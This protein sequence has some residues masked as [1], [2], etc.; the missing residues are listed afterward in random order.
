[1]LL[2]LVQLRLQQV[3]Q[4][5]FRQLGDYVLAQL[6]GLDTGFQ[7]SGEPVADVSQRHKDLNR[8]LSTG[9]GVAGEA[10]R[11]YNDLR[12]A[13]EG[14]RLVDEGIVQLERFTKLG[15]DDKA[16]A[17]SRAMVIFNS[18]VDTG[19]LATTNL[20]GV[21]GEIR[22]TLKATGIEG[23][24]DLKTFENFIRKFKAQAIE[25]Q[26]AA[27]AAEAMR[28]TLERAAKATDFFN[29][30]VERL[31]KA[32]ETATGRIIAGMDNISSEVDQILTDRFK[33]TAVKSINPFEDVRSASPRELEAGFRTIQRFNPG[34]DLSELRELTNVQRALPAVLQSVVR[35]AEAGNIGD[36][37]SDLMPEIRKQLLAVSPNLQGEFFRELEGQIFAPGA[38]GQEQQAVIPLDQLRKAAKGSA[39]DISKFGGIASKTLARLL[40]AQQKFVDGLV[41]MGNLR[42]KVL[43]DRINREMKS[44]DRRIQLQDALN[45]ALGRTPNE[46]QNATSN[47]QERLDTLAAAGG[48]GARVN[49]VGIGQLFRNREQGLA[50][51]AMA[52]AEARRPG[53]SPDRQAFLLGRQIPRINTFLNSNTEA[54]KQLANDTTR[55]AAA[56][57]EMENSFR[58]EAEAGR[59]I[60]Q[61]GQAIVDL[62]TGKLST[63]EFRKQVATPIA[64]FEEFF[65][66]LT[67]GQQVNLSGQAGFELSQMLASGDPLL[68]AQFDELFRILAIQR[69]TDPGTERR[70]I[71]RELQDAR[72]RFSLQGAQGNPDV[73]RFL[74]R[75]QQITNRERRSQQAGA[76]GMRNI[77]AVQNQ[78]A[79]RLGISREALVQNQ[80]VI[81]ATLFSKAVNV[82]SAAV[83]NFTGRPTK[84]MEKGGFVR[85]PSHAA[86]GVLTELEGGEFVIPKKFFNRGGSVGGNTTPY[87][88]SREEW[89]NRLRQDEYRDRSLGHGSRARGGKP[90]T[91]KT[92][93]RKGKPKDEGPLGP[94]LTFM[95]GP[96]VADQPWEGGWWKKPPVASLPAARV[97]PGMD[98]EWARITAI[99][100]PLKRFDAMQKYTRDNSRAKA[101]RPATGARPGWDAYVR[102]AEQQSDAAVF[103]LGYIADDVLLERVQAEHAR[104]PVGPHPPHTYAGAPITGQFPGETFG[105]F[106]QR[107]LREQRAVQDRD[108]AAMA[109][110]RRVTSTAYYRERERRRYRISEVKRKYPMQYNASGMAIGRGP[111]GTLAMRYAMHGRKGEGKTASERD[112]PL[113]VEPPPPPNV[114]QNTPEAEALRERLR[115]RREHKSSVPTADNRSWFR[116]FEAGAE[117]ALGMGIGWTV[118]AI[119][120]AGIGVTGT[121]GNLKDIFMGDIGWDSRGLAS[122]ETTKKKLL[123]NYARSRGVWD[124]SFGLAGKHLL[125]PTAKAWDHFA[126]TPLRGLAGTIGYQTG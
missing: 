80:E 19:K 125:I 44:V 37:P 63:G 104:H 23:E 47:L 27:A 67:T 57:R 75:N 93:R 113:F 72:T 98:P 2:V 40:N 38:R 9:A 13:A 42:Q 122:W 34:A 66:K 99:K 71:E 60:T 76:Q 110:H 21:F 3:Q 105:D 86:G 124:E 95:S 43:Q 91:R 120:E 82:F 69:G 5:T 74:Q 97:G 102:Q 65:Q 54:L 50:L 24:E 92:F 94:N 85:G 18:R 15:L 68:K 79:Q 87:G 41:K 114:F 31:S 81:A 1:M 53:I 109:R 90:K 59:S 49:N 121:V 32:F 28:R 58:R 25:N 4:S 11:R 118:G 56:T 30:A 51:R 123:K 26:E 7:E 70:R 14:T 126:A 107:N 39:Q 10:A 29:D 78:I 103:D 8:I 22:K 96:L 64:I 61:I 35:M 89:L 17:F 36:R 73:L 55:L 106:Q 112:R 16:N 115:R 48:T 108:A 88:I 20:N 6:Q 119:K 111:E 101:A 33:V 100:D 77:V 62:R 83:A 12:N 46:L 52:E 45:T 116:R 117:Q 84:T